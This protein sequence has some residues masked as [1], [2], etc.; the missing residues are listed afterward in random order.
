[1]T[2]EKS[3]L[4]ISGRKRDIGG[5]VVARTIPSVTRRH[6]GPF[7]FLDHMGPMK[8]DDTHAL[9][10]RPHP[11]IGLSTVTY[12]FSG[13]G[14]HKDSLGFSQ[15]ITPGDINWMTAG[16]GIVHSERSPQEDRN[17]PA[18]SPLHGIQ[19]WVAL[20]VEDEDTDPNFTHYSQSVIPDL[21][22]GPA[23]HGKLMIGEH[24]GVTSPVK[25][26][27]KTFFADLKAHEAVAQTFTIDEK[28]IGIF[29]VEGTATIN[30]QELSVDDLIVVKDPQSISIE[31]D[32][33]AR[34]IFIGGTPFD[35][36]RFIWW[37][38]VSS[39]VEKIRHAAKQWE[40]QEMGK[41]PGESEF[42]PLPNI[43]F[44]ATIGAKS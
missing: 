26:Y 39:S 3:D 2:S 19:V 41:V 16:R 22:F 43:S 23:L 8:I 42:T 32:K 44:P 30:G 6:V 7:V 33:D 38:L 29:L 14:H 35:E 10:V 12:L 17:P 27:S 24:Q 18:K 4:I 28:E 11:H 15:V 34:L 37:N 13:R 31:A 20:P 40:N 25:T 1:M 5:F 21:S 36:P 9:D